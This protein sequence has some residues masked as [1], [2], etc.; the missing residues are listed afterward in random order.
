MA[1]YKKTSEKE[2]ILGAMRRS[3]S[4]LP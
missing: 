1:G 3:V 4:R 2:R